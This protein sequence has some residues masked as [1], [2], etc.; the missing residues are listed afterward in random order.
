MNAFNITSPKCN[1]SWTECKL[2]RKH[3]T[4]ETYTSF[5]L[6]GSCKNILSSLC[7]IYKVTHLQERSNISDPWTQDWFC[8]LILS[9][10]YIRYYSVLWAQKGTQQEWP[11]LVYL[12]FFSPPLGCEHC[13]SKAVFD[14]VASPL[15]QARRKGGVELTF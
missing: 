5:M 12:F 15:C 11:S 4:Q 7:I 14:L 9:S 6:F 1:K 2:I 8:N 13:L 10:Q 3:E